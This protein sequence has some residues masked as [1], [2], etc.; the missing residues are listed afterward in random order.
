[1]LFCGLGF[2]W[3]GRGGGFCHDEMIFSG[4]ALLEWGGWIYAE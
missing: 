4:D 1:M 3:E 2:K